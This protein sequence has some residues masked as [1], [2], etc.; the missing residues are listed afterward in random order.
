ML[1]V[2]AFPLGPERT[3]D[4]GR[5]ALAQVDGTPVNRDADPIT[6]V[7]AIEGRYRYHRAGDLDLP[8]HLHDVGGR[9]VI[10]LLG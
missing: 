8:D 1:G 7:P 9:F 6:L 10:D 5:A 3:S 4:I 2:L